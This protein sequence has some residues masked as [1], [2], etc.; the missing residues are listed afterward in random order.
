MKEPGFVSTDFR[1][2]GE[3]HMFHDRAFV[4]FSD[5]CSKPIVMKNQVSLRVR[6]YINC[7]QKQI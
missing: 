6:E 2:K 5:A 7:C 3:D 1:S 4:L